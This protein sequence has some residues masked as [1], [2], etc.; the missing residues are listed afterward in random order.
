MRA[1]YFSMR[2]VWGL[3]K[4]TNDLPIYLEPVAKLTS[5]CVRLA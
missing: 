4:K 1:V 2:L 5:F 3:R